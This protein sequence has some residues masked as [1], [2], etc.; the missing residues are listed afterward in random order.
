MNTLDLKPDLVKILKEA[1]LRYIE[2][3]VPG[4]KRRK[5]GSGFAYFDIDGKI[6]S[7]NTLVRIKD[8]NIPPAWRDVWICPSSTGYL[9]ATG[10]DS[11]GRKQYLYHPKWKEICQENKFSKLPEFARALPKIREKVRRD[12]SKQF[13]DKEQ[14]LATVIW[15]LENTLIRVGNDE[16][17]KENN[18]FGLTTL[19]NRHVHVKGKRVSF[20]FTG[21]SGVDHKIEVINPRIA[22]VIK[23]CIE[24]PGYEIFQYVDDEG[25]RHSIDSGQVNLYLKEMTG[26]DVTAKDF[27]TWGGSSLAAESFNSLGTYD[28]EA[29]LKKVIHQTVTEVSKHLG[30]TAKI[31]LNYYIHPLIVETYRKKVF[32]P[33]YRHALNSDKKIAGLSKPE[34]AVLSLIEKYS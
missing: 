27:R 25:F 4:I 7:K 34:F 8:L 14:L 15:L 16:Y 1:Q 30:N 20:N 2:G 33:F 6:T 5:T 17:A 23:E 21:K 18:H 9:Q 29:G 19:R 31:C 12:L 22:K 24:L 32:V 3:T 11:K 26:E 10:L 13:L 28:N